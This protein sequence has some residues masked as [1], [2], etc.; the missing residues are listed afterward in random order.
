MD[1][2]APAPP[3]V[4]KPFVVKSGA[5]CFGTPHNIRWG[6]R[7]P[8]QQPTFV[9][10]TPS[11]TVLTHTFQYNL[12]ALNGVWSAYPLV[13]AANNY[14]QT[15]SSS[16]SITVRAWF[17]CHE[18][19]LLEDDGP[20]QE[21]KRIL[22]V[23]NSPYEADNGV[24]RNTSK[25]WDNRVLVVNRYD[26][27][28]EDSRGYEEE[29]DERGD[30]YM[31]KDVFLV[32]YGY[33][34]KHEAEATTF[35]HSNVWVTPPPTT[36][37]TASSSSSRVNE[38]ELPLGVSMVIPDAEYI[39]GRFGL[40]DDQKHV[41][42]F[43]YFTGGTELSQT[44]FS[45]D[46]RGGQ[47]RPIYVQLTPEQRHAKRL[48]DGSYTG[49]DFIRTTISVPPAGLLGPFGVELLHR[50]QLLS[51][52]QE[53]CPNTPFEPSLF[54]DMAQLL[55]ECL[56]SWIVQ[57][58]NVAAAE[59]TSSVRQSWLDHA[60]PRRTETQS[61]DSFIL[62]FIES[63]EETVAPVSVNRNGLKELLGREDHTLWTYMSMDSLDMAVHF[64]MGEVL[65]LAS[66]GACDNQRSVLVP[67]DLRVAIGN[68]MEL[69]E[70]LGQT[71][72]YYPPDWWEA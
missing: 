13:Y 25:T 57:L 2:P 63:D 61:V 39:F 59:D 58:A 21:A 56:C 69:S 40:A 43:L 64:L 60:F 46:P 62:K 26:W 9:E 5:I 32:D 47:Q 6:A 72:Q 24:N 67:C 38:Q 4:V 50:D 71:K 44:V 30:N 37:T 7:Q 55:N 45:M 48:A 65:E 11:G 16:S 20:Y 35:V 49:F 1:P 15:T 19:F 66:N 54:D 52:Q 12:A 17:A 22:Q 8:L 31:M 28:Y 34:S 18:S 70:K 10:P 53:K 23:A 36:A 41:H 14:P 27:G 51:I 29:Q 33:A 3:A 42:S 68:D